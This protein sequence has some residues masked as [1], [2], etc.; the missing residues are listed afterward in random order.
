MWGDLLA[1]AGL[2]L[3]LVGAVLTAR[4]VILSEDQALDIGVAS[5]VSGQRE[6]DLQLPSVQNLLQ[7]SRGARRGLFMIALGTFMQ[8]CP[9]ALAVFRSFA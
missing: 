8:A 1:L 4:S 7:A 2:S 6:E 9:V 3:T 5:Y